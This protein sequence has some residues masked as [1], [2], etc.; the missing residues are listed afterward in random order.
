MRYQFGVIFMGGEESR[1]VVSAR[2][3]T[4]LRR[5]SEYVNTFHGEKSGLLAQDTG[6]GASDSQ[7]QC[8]DG[9]SSGVPHDAEELDDMN[10]VYN[11]ELAA[12]LKQFDENQTFLRMEEAYIENAYFY[13]AY[14]QRAEKVT[15]AHGCRCALVLIRTL[16]WFNRLLQVH[17]YAG[18]SSYR[19]STSVEY[20]KET[21]YRQL[22]IE[23]PSATQMAE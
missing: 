11:E 10:A 22:C 13:Q 8:G 2:P 12:R 20:I 17:R 18:I 14:A 6:S 23:V 15:Y 19:R 16:D 4:G 9:C 7:Q 5:Y 21:Q 1:F 3:F